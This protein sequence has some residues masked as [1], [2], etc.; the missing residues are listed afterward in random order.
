MCVYM[1][2]DIRAQGERNKIKNS[3]IR[4]T[5]SASEARVALSPPF[6]DLMVDMVEVLQPDHTKKPRRAAESRRRPADRRN[7]DQQRRLLTILLAANAATGLSAVC[8]VVYSDARGSPTRFFGFRCLQNPSLSVTSRG[9][10]HSSRHTASHAHFCTHSYGDFR[11]ETG[12]FAGRF[13]LN[14]ALPAIGLLDYKRRRTELHAGV[15]FFAGNLEI[16]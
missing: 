7:C 3:L 9:E 15:L 12:V 14:G 13:L 16:Y 6:G 5:T 2:K 10:H 1:Q 8:C 4:D 11:L